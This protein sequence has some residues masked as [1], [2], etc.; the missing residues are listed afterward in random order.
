[1]TGD[2]NRG[3]LGLTK[4]G[5]G[6]SEPKPTKRRGR[7]PGTRLAGR[8]A[9]GGDQVGQA[10]LIESVW[11]L[12]RTLPPDKI[13]RAAVARHAGVDPALINYH[14]VDRSSLLRAAARGLLDR[15]QV[16]VA[17]PIEAI[18][19]PERRLRARIAGFLRFQI[20]Y[21]FFHRLVSEEVL[22]AQTPAAHDLLVSMAHQGMVDYRGILEAGETTGTMRHVDP[23]LLYLA[24]V[25]L[26]EQAAIG[27]PLLAALDHPL[28]TSADYADRIADFICDLLLKGLG[29]P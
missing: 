12:L 19:D 11:A 7:P 4:L 22:S 21:P 16:E 28:A 15:F 9:A 13:T 5:S 18:G 24:I 25:G 20:D 10:A 14:F 17:K 2:R 6:A 27:R 29:S 3:M 1:M 8:P 23:A 26:V